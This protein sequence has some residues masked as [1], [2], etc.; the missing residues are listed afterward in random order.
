MVKDAGATTSQNYLKITL[1]PAVVKQG[2]SFTVFVDSANTLKE[3]RIRGLK[4]NQSIYRI[5]HKKHKHVFRG[6]IGVPAALKPG[7]YKIIA[8]AVDINDE[9]LRIY[10]TVK[11]KK[12]NFK[13][14]H[15]NLPKKKTSLINVE[16][17]KEEGRVLSRK[18]G[19]KSKKVYFGDHFIKPARGRISSRFGSRRK[20]NDEEFSSYH[21]GIDIANVKGTPV[22]ASNGGQVSLARNMKANGK[23]VLINHGHGITTIYSHLNTIKVKE[24]QWIKRGR[25]IGLIGSTGISSGPHLHFGFSVNNV[26]VDPEPW[27]SKAVTIYY[28]IP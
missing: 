7:N 18:L 6:F 8:E 15:I 20:Y 9:K 23:I 10:Q 13:T 12:G 11:V 19:L 21:K 4:R 17:L 22:K 25:V 2:Q 14:Q 26:R 24:G 5:W 28:A 1:S 16:I 27:L 3:L